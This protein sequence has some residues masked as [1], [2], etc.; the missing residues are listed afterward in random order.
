M[1]KSKLKK[2]LLNY[3]A[4][5]FILFCGIIIISKLLFSKVPQN[6]LLII[7]KFLKD[8]FLS[9]LLIEV[10]VRIGKNNTTIKTNESK[11]LNLNNELSK[12]ESAYD[13]QAYK[14]V[15]KEIYDIQ[16]NQ[17]PYI[18]ETPFLEKLNNWIAI[19]ICGLSILVFLIE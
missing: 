5:Y 11:L 1:D 14:K 2:H 12:L 4:V 17:V 9:Y 18:M 7:L 8:A 19:A 13:F 16:A 3:R 6:S 15:K 10:T